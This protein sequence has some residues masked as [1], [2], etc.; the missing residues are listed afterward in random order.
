MQVLEVGA[1]HLFMASFNEHTGGRQQSS[2]TANTAILMGLPY[3]PQNRTVWAD[4]YASEFSRD[5][6]PTKEAGERLWQVVTS[7]VA[8][9]KEGRN[10]SQHDGPAEL[11]CKTADTEVFANV[12]SF[13]R[14]DGNDAILTSNRTEAALL[15]SGAGDGGSSRVWVEQ[16]NAVPCPTVF[17][18]NTSV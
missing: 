6:E 3:D 1:P 14:E 8:M 10:C 15:K 2:Y 11:C 4:T 18:T 5:L 12:W 13:W 9:Y 17:C 7:C 16:C